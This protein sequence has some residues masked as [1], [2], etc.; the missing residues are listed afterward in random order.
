MTGGPMRHIAACL[1]ILTIA[2]T[3]CKRDLPLTTT[4]PEA[5]HLYRQGVR[6]YERFFYS[7]SKDFFEK[8]IGLDSSFAMAWTRLG[9]VYLAIR[10]EPEALVCLRNAMRQS[11]K[12]SERERLFIHMWYYRVTFDSKTSAAVADSLALR[13]P[14]EKEVYLFRG[15]LYEQAKNYEAAIRSYQKAIQTDTGYALAVMTLGY[16]YS[17][18]GEQEKAVVQ[19]QRYIRLAPDEPDPR[20]SYADILLR[21]GRFDEAL[22]QYQESLRLKP[23]YWYSL[24]QIGEIDAIKGKLKE[25]EK[26]YHVSMQYLP[27]NRQLESTEAQLRGGLEYLR[28]NYPAAVTLYRQALASDTLNLDAAFGLLGTYARTGRF[29]EAHDAIARVYDEF[30]I[31]ELLNSPAMAAL[32]VM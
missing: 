6:Q 25:A 7:E 2:L 19:M 9:I 10:D 5:E 13:Y 15:N 26:E 22:E 29:A 27:Q 14:Q 18:I 28:G 32:F 31:R 30:R 4:S 16:A 8:A 20:A 17:S 24:R 12:V 3:G 11:D 23:D 21:A 1:M